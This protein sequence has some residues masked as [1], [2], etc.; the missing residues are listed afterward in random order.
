MNIQTI[1]NYAIRLI[2]Y[3]LLVTGALYSIEYFESPSKYFTFYGYLSEK[4]E[5]RFPEPIKSIIIGESYH[6][7]LDINFTDILWCAK[8]ESGE[9]PQLVSVF[10]RVEK[11]FVFPNA[12]PDDTL[13]FAVS[14]DNPLTKIGLSEANKIR[15]N[16]DNELWELDFVVPFESS[17]CYISA[18]V[19]TYTRIFNIP[20]TV[21]FDGNTF[22]YL[23]PED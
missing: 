5:Y 7:P 17:T 14:K 19:T 18:E 16:T 8:Y 23:F 1:R 20:K 11:D 3:A 12:I 2:L 15:T 22:T 10:N 4:E 9:T 13:L 6:G 21:Y